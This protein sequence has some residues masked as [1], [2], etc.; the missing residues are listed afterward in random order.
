MRATRTRTRRKSLSKWFYHFL[1]NALESIAWGI[2][3]IQLGDVITDANGVMKF[4]DVELVPRDHVCPEYGV[5]LRDRSDSPQQ[6]IPYREVR[7]PTG[8]WRSARAATSV[9]C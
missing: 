1:L 7:W 8:A 2:P 3:L 4:S 9:C 6:G 5:L